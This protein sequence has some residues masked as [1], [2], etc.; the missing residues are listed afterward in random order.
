MKFPEESRKW[1]VIFGAAISSLAARTYAADGIELSLAS[2][3]TRF[4]VAEPV[5]LAA[6][7]KNDGGNAKSLSV[8]I[9]HE[10]GSAF[11][12]SVPVD[13]AS[14]QSQSR[15]VT[16]QPGALKAGVYQAAVK[17]DSETKPVE[18]AVHPDEHSNAYWTA[19]WVHHGATRE[20]TLAKGGWMYLNGDYVSLHPRK[21]APNDIAEGYVAAG[22]KPYALMICGG[23]HQLDLQLENDWGDPWVQRAVIWKMQLGA[24]SNRLYP[25]SG[26][27]VFDEPGLTWWPIKDSAGKPV[28][29][30]PY[31]IPHQLEEFKKVNGKEM[32][33]GKFEDTLPTYA[34]RMDDWL[35]FMDMRMKYLE[36]A[37]YGSV[38]GTRSVAPQLGTVNQVSSSY[39][40]HDATDGV[41]SRQNRP[42]EILSGHGQY[43]D[44]PFG[45]LQ[46]LRGAEGNRGF[47]WDKPH[48]YLPMW[49]THTWATIRAA[50]WISW[51]SK[52]EGMLYTPEQDFGLNNGPCGYFGSD[53]IFEIA[54]INRRLAMVGGVMNQLPQTLAPVAV[55]QSHTQVAWDIAT[56]NHPQLTKSG[57][58]PYASTHRDAVNACFFRLLDAGMIP[59]TVDEVETIEKG[60]EFLKQWKVIF[61]PAL[62]I[63]TPKFRKALEDYVAAG[64]KLIQFK[65]DKLMISGSIVA[66][67]TVPDP[68]E[69]YEKN[70]KAN[71][72]A[73]A[74]AKTAGDAAGETAANAVA[75]KA[76]TDLAYRQ[77]NNAGAPNFAAELAEWLGPQ[78]YAGSNREILLAVHSA[79][80]AHYLLVANNA[81]SKENPRMIK[82]ELIPAET[83]VQIPAGGVIYDLFNGGKVNVADGG[84]R[85][86]LAAGDGAC[87]LHLPE[88]PAKMKLSAEVRDGDKLE[89]QLTWGKTGYLPF[90]LRI[91]DPAGNKAGDYY[92]A[93]TPGK[94]E[95]SFRHVYALGKNSA[96]GRWRVVV[97]EWLTGARV[98]RT[99]SVKS[100]AETKIARVG[101]DPV[102]IY[103]EDGRRIT[104]LFAGKLVEPDWKQLNWDAKR[105]FALDPKRFAVFAPTN[106]VAAAGKV[107]AALSGKGLSVELNPKYESVPFKREPNRGVSG[108]VGPESNFENIYAN[109]IV[110]P[111][112][113]LA[114]QSWNRGHINRPVTAAFPGPGRAYIQW[115][116][117]CYQAG[118]QNVFVFGD[119]D[120]GVAWLLAAIQGT[121]P[122]SPFSELAARIT[123][124]D[125]TAPAYAKKFSV[126][127]TI[128]TYDTPV[129]IGASPDG[130]TTYVALYDGSVLAYDRGG[131]ELWNTPALLEASALAVSPKGDRIAVAGYPGLLVLDAASGK[132][133]DGYRAA[134]KAI[135]NGVLI[136][137]IVNIAWNSDGSKV[138][139]GWVQNIHKGT[140]KADPQP[141]I[142]LD[143]NGKRLA[144]PQGFDGNV[145]GVAFVPGSDTLLIGTDKLTAINAS[146]GA[147]LWSNDISGAQSFAFSADGQTAAAG[148]W[149]K[150]AGRFNLSDGKLIQSAT[151]D[152]IVGGTAFLPDG[153][154]AVAV[155]GGTHP[156]YVL[157]AG[158]E[159]SE[160][161][162]QSQFGFH[163]VIWSEA[164][165]GL[166]ATEEGGKVWL[167][168][169]D[170]QPQAMLDEESG[171]TAYRLLPRDKDVMV[172]RMNRVVQQLTLE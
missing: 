117:S 64:G 129:G 159:K 92:R 25:I 28:G 137:R 61:C 21:P 39:A 90:R 142:I 136:N 108:P 121:T 99:F 88:P 115:G 106:Q 156:L 77:W 53:T 71:Q 29:M 135:G 87:L 43:S 44:L 10:D 75:Y 31:S 40:P 131:K 153:D 102:S 139:G 94:G 130:R 3:R 100:V 123:P 69:Y 32:P 168:G 93:T 6:L 81:Q 59:N 11:S 95:P 98:E 169:A 164:D 35:A 22:M 120:A 124:K 68:M 74:K 152:S 14:G 133:L 76:S 5:E 85:L 27:H 132:G 56:L 70:I 160:A 112:H 122:P 82:H 50:V 57:S 18:F 89:V 12:L 148:G 83:T 80:D 162:F 154:V 1:I 20:T 79:G 72:D 157:H 145:Y 127:K 54:E 128:P 55:M 66:D 13:A 138:A 84:V 104:D 41:D 15:L 114:E 150:N 51:V 34:G 67:H 19:Q 47:S 166:V 171:T 96:P 16:L 42:Y 2:T 52:L 118:W 30:N 101:T 119:A 97:D 141:V 163:N 26:L 149:G 78:P 7:Y 165:H 147:A 62:T 17:L 109:T 113:P 158:A 4:T 143:A 105:V 146:N 49:Y 170:G 37:W 167:L 45:T 155:W 91:F 73:A 125:A 65:G 134:P 63:A 140:L 126:A 144:S 58:P 24:L 111:G 161:F 23:G 36:Q 33:S 86:K 60:A 48:Y 9:R 116:S 172:A 151:F 38:W 46:P 103:V 107:V 8:E 110:L